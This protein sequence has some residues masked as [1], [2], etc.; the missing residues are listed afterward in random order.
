[1]HEQQLLPCIFGYRGE[2]DDMGLLRSPLWQICSGSLGV[3]ALILLGETIRVV[4]P[5][6]ERVQFLGLCFQVYH[7][8]KTRTKELDGYGFVGS[9]HVQRIAFEAAHTFLNNVR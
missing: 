9:N 4:S 2:D 1:M 8:T 7:Y 6:V 5:C 3:D